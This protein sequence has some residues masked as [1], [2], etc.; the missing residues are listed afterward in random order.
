METEE[1]IIRDSIDIDGGKNYEIATLHVTVGA[2][3][4]DVIVIDAAWLTETVGAVIGDKI[5]IDDLSL[6]IAPH[7]WQS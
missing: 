7:Y 1:A 3:I 4:G 2:V 6:V 5:D